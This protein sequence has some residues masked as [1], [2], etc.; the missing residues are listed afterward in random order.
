MRKSQYERL[1]DL[2]GHGLQSSGDQ[3]Q[4]NV[5]IT[6]RVTLGSISS[7]IQT[8]PNILP[9][10]LENNTAPILTNSFTVK[11]LLKE[12]SYDITGLTGDTN[13]GRFKE[14][15]ASATEIPPNRQRLIVAGKQLQPN[16]A[17]LSAFK[18]NADNTTVHLFPLPAA[19]SYVPSIPANSQN[20]FSNNNT[21]TNTTRNP[22]SAV[23][24]QADD[25]DRITPHGPVFYDPFVQVCCKEIRVWSA[26]LMFLSSMAV[27]VS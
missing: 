3:G 16:D 10:D 23:I 14:L 13:V 21:A 17:K 1:Q 27:R 4:E 22:M 19:N 24:M 6:T 5:E 20:H 2:S 25:D 7:P 26:L 11:V 15:V 8:I 9:P 18:L 12:S